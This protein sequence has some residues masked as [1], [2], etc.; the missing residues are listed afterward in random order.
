MKRKEKPKDK[1]FCI[2]CGLCCMRLDIVLA[3]RN[4]TTEEVAKIMDEFPYAHTNGRCEKLNDDM[5]CSVYEDR[6]DLCNVEKFGKR[7][8]P[9]I[10]EQLH[11]LMQE[12]ACRTIIKEE[13]LYT[14]KELNEIYRTKKIP[15]K[16]WWIIT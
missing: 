10:P 2:G 7:A 6:P 4:N 1:F 16:L 8:V 9:E 13:G 14:E 5:T 3:R 12:S 11:Y 15:K